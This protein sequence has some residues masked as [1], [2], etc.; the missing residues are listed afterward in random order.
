LREI[1]SPQYIS[2]SKIDAHA[3]NDPD[4]NQ[5]Q[6]DKQSSSNVIDINKYDVQSIFH[7]PII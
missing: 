1:P 7:I 6:I 4:A 5:E 3:D 2:L